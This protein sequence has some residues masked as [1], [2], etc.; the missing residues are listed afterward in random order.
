MR[1]AG[2]G[3]QAREMGFTRGAPG[4]Q[5]QK[6]GERPQIAD[7][8]QLPHVSLHIRGD[9]VREPLVRRDRAIKDSRIGA[10]PQDLE[11]LGRGRL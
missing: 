4:A 6:G 11:Q 1:N 5:L 7:I 9:V 8:E 3:T 2:I 10:G